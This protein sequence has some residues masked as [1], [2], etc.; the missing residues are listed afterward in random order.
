VTQHNRGNR[1]NRRDRISL[2]NCNKDK[3][4][5]IVQKYLVEVERSV[6]PK[7]KKKN[8]CFFLFTCVIVENKVMEK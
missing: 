1:R 2:K 5:E 6:K 7:V 4:V 8:V 3:M